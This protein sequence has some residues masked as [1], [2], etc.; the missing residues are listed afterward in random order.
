[1]KKVLSK[2]KLV[3]NN[4]IMIV[5]FVGIFIPYTNDSNDVILSLLKIADIVIFFAIFSRKSIMSFLVSVFSICLLIKQYSR[6]FSPY[7]LFN[8]EFMIGE[9]NPLKLAYEF[10]LIYFP[11]KYFIVIITVLLMFWVLISLNTLFKKARLANSRYGIVNNFYKISYRLRII[12]PFIAYL[13]IINTV[14]SCFANMYSTCYNDFYLKYALINIRDERK[15]VKELSSDK[16]ERN[17][18]IYYKDNNEYNIKNEK[19][20]M[21]YSYSENPSYILEKQQ[22]KSHNG[23][24]KLKTKNDVNFAPDSI[25]VDTKYKNGKTNHYF[26]NKSFKFSNEKSDELV[27]VDYSTFLYFSR[28]TFFTIGYGDIIPTDYETQNLVGL[29]ALTAHIL[30]VI[31]IPILFIVV[32]EI[33]NKKD[34]EGKDFDKLLEDISEGDIIEKNAD[35]KKEIQIKNKRFTINIIKREKDD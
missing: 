29:E 35:G 27:P 15:V 13:I 20:T 10:Y 31:F 3:N 23:E 11:K 30:S 4:W 17:Y 6:T 34:S 33:L 21:I 7:S 12:A 2:S 24:Y 18:V 14:I 25:E 16:T 9:K 1:M 28:I 5:L 26:I 8:Y 19:V 22:N 32:Q